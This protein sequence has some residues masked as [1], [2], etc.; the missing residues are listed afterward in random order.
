MHQ[1]M[2]WYPGRA[3][4]V[5]AVALL[6]ACGASPTATPQAAPPVEFST[7]AGDQVSLAALRGSVVVLNFWASWCAPCRSEMPAFDAAARR[8]GD[9]GVVVVGL[10]TKDSEAAARAFA[11]EIGVGYRLG[12]DQGDQIAATYQVYGLPSTLFIDR[13]GRIARRVPGVLSEA[14][15]AEYIEE[16]LRPGATGG[17]HGAT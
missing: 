8:Y 6:L 9:Q 7:F 3:V 1:S 17:D 15:L 10:A 16:V 13:Q 4:T 11:A 14:Q 12:F 2:R 5:L